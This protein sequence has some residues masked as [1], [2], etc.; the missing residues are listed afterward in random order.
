MLALE[1]GHSD[2]PRVARF[3]GDVLPIRRAPR[4]T[5]AHPPEAITSSG[6]GVSFG[7]RVF[8]HREARCAA[9]NASLS[10]SASR[11][12]LVTLALLSVP[13]VAMNFTEEVN[14]G[15]EDF[16]AAG[17]LLFAA[18]MAY[19]LAARHVRSTVHRIFVAALVLVA[20][21]AVWAQLAVGLFT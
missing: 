8:D 18:G 3:D 14:W 7:S 16:L 10:R 2:C 15:F 21:A 20:L 11:T 5:S 6:L 12:A 9:V 19:S 13:L 17:G 4:R 1:V